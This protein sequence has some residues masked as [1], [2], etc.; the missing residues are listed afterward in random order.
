MAH[1][2]PRLAPRQI[3]IHPSPSP[4]SLLQIIA[5]D[6]LA[7][8]EHDTDA[9]PVLVTTHEPLVGAVEAELTKQLQELATRAVA[10][11]SVS[12]VRL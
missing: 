5:A 9:L 4:H 8:A 2:R 10:A 6:L 7:Q 12:K 1:V 11:V 3:D